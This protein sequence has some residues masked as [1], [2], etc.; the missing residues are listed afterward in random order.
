MHAHKQCAQFLICLN[1]SVRVLLDD[2][3]TR[4]E[5]I[6]DRPEMGIYMPPMIWGTQYRYSSDAILLV[7]ASLEYNSEDYIRNYDEFVQAIDINSNSSL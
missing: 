7:F 5:V 6:L 4:R 3:R 1:G 2:S